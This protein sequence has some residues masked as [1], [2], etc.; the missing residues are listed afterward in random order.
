M[1]ANLREP[2]LWWRWPLLPFASVIGATAG[3][4][5]YGLLWYFFSGAAPESPFAHYIL[6][7]LAGGTFGYLVPTISHKVAPAGKVAAAISMTV[8]ALVLEI[9]GIAILLADTQQ[10]SP[11]IQNVIYVAAS[12]IVGIYALR[13]MHESKQRSAALQ[14]RWVREESMAREEEFSNSLIDRAARP[15]DNDGPPH[16]PQHRTKSENTNVSERVQFRRS[17]KAFLSQE[18]EYEV[19]S[20]QKATL[21]TTCDEATKAGLLPGDAAAMFIEVLCLALERPASEDGSSEPLTENEAAF[22]ERMSLTIL[23]SVNRGRASPENFPR[24][25]RLYLLSKGAP[26]DR[27]DEVDEMLETFAKAMAQGRKGGLHYDAKA[28]LGLLLTMAH[29]RGI[30]PHLPPSEG[31]TLTCRA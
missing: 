14:E 11:V 21:T 1:S 17:V 26:V 3:G 4:A 28:T 10:E 31:G 15:S 27:L 30:V 19:A 8:I 29:A 5:A 22:V 9:V 7:L 2:T 24:A 23:A 16:A 13:E 18:Y 12:V 20:W 6:P 25:T